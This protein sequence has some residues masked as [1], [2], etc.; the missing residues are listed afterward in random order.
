MCLLPRYW[1][2]KLGSRC[3]KYR[4]ASWSWAVI[5]C[6]PARIW[7]KEASNPRGDP[8]AILNTQYLV[9]SAVT[10]YYIGAYTTYYT[11][12]RHICQIVL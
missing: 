6:L 7:P 4:Q 2:S 3:V 11:Y 10:I 12:E 5:C 8:L 9:I 1:S